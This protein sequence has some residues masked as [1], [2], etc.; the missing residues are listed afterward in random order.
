MALMI[1]RKRGRARGYPM[2]VY[3][4]KCQKCDRGFEVSRSMTEAEGHLTCPSC[5]STQIDRVYTSVFAKTSK[6]S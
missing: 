3:E 4:Y 6:K 1:A 5:G 2:P